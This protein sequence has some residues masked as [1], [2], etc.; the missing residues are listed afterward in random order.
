MSLSGGFPP[1]SLFPLAGMQLQLAS[2]GTVDISDVRRLPAAHFLS[3]AAGGACGIAP[4]RV[5]CW[6]REACMLHA[7]LSSLQGGRC[8]PSIPHSTPPRAFC[9]SQVTAAQ[10]YNFSLRG[11]AP[12]LSWA[13]RHTAAMHA[14]PPGAGHQLLVTNGGNHTLEVG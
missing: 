5:R 11:Y 8:P 3:V 1:P 10:Q 9:V 13:E 14:P 6:R 4:R 2:G 12:L 7:G